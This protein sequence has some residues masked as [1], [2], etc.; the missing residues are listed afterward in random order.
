VNRESK[1][2]E[3]EG[4][5]T[6]SQRS[7]LEIQQAL[8]PL[9]KDLHCLDP[10]EEDIPNSLES[11]QRLYKR[12]EAS[13]VQKTK[14]KVSFWDWFRGYTGSWVMAGGVAM[15]LI[16]VGIWSY[17]LPDELTEKGNVLKKQ[18][19]T[20]VLLTAKVETGGKNSRQVGDGE[21]CHESQ[22]LIFR[23]RLADKAHPGYMYLL[24]RNRGITFIYPEKPSDPAL[25]KPGKIHDIYAG[26]EYAL[27]GEKGKVRFLLLKSSRPLNEKELQ[28]L[29]EDKDSFQEWIDGL[30]KMEDKELTMTWDIL[31]LQVQARP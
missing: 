4:P 22:S 11:L 17:G 13:S 19:D 8:A 14:P 21:I 3:F 6:T 2:P 30:S 26:Q 7:E 15:M 1:G 18:E 29:R 9:L 23:F 12:A 24:K 28:F 5:Q 20:V 25:A 31:S 27:K 10:R 16:S